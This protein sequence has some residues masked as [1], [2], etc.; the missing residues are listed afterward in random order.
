MSVREIERLQQQLA[1][2][3]ED[4]SEYIGMWVALRD[5]RVIAAAGDPATLRENPIVELDDALLQVTDGSDGFLF[6]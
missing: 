5:G 6:V 4:L 1:P 3:D 2:K